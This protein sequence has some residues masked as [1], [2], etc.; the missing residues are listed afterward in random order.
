M[1]SEA[2][3]FWDFRA[4]VSEETIQGCAVWVTSSFL[5]SWASRYQ[6][7]THP[8]MSPFMKTHIKLR[9]DLLSRYL[10]WLGTEAMRLDDIFRGRKA[11]EENKTD[12]EFK[13][14]T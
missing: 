11:V 5:Q 2:A 9:T 7:G 12:A 3:E 14:R 4:Y 13:S 6:E 10:S 8:V 1:E